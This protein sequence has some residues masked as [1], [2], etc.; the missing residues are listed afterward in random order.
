P[1]ICNIGAGSIRRDGHAHWETTQSDRD[2][3]TLDRIGG[4]V[5]HR[6]RAVARVR[7]IDMGP[8]WRDGN[9]GRLHPHRNSGHHGVAGGGDHRN[10]IAAT[11]RH[12]HT[13]PTRGYSY[14]TPNAGPNVTFA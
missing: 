7:D 2:R 1:G 13:T 6:D 14:S 12:I 5:D 9:P 3:G 10:V 11:I 8:I 4:C